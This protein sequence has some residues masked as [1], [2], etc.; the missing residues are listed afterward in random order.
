MA[1]LCDPW[2]RQINYLRVSVTDFCNLNCVYC[3]EEPVPRLPMSEILTYEEIGRLISVASAIGITKV[4][5]TGGEPFLRPQFSKLVAMTAKTPGIDDISATTN[6][7]LLARYAGELKEAGLNRVNV[8]LDTLR[9]DRFK[10]I[11]RSDS[12]EQVIAGIELA[13]RVGLTPVKIN[14]VVM[15]GK[16]D[17]EIVDFARKTIEN[18]WNIRYIEDMPFGN[19]ANGVDSMVSAREIQKRIEVLGRLEPCGTKRGNGPARY[20]RFPNASGTI[21]FISP[22]TEHF[23]GTCNRLRITADGHLRPCLLDDDEIDVKEALRS[24]ASDD[25]LRELIEQAVSVKRERHHLNEGQRAP[26]KSMR[27]IGG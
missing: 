15:R 20:F 5:F 8:S 14:M 1:G 16:N 22:V 23:C 7:T 24:G 9:P 26:V 21:G 3:S 12:L 18:G 13:D 10:Q 11:T 19:P 25:E 17:D 27:Q 2:H 4:R 6:G